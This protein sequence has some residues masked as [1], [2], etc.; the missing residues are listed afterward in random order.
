MYILIKTLIYHC[1]VFF[2]FLIIFF[3]AKKFFVIFM[4]I[5]FPDLFLQKAANAEEKRLLISF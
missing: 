3:D 2:N 5:N 4:K 1:H